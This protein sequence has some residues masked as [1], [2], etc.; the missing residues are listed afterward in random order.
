MKRKRPNRDAARAGKRRKTGDVATDRPSYPLLRKYYPEVV[1]LRQ[2][3]ASRL[4]KKRRRRLQQYGKDGDQTVCQLL[5]KT[6]IGAFQ[7][8][9]VEDSSVVDDDISTFTQQLTNADSSI[10]LTP[11][12][13]KQSEVGAN[14]CLIESV[15]AL[16]DSTDGK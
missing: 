6:V 10:T 7:H 13:F 5:D 3:L 16:E 11:G 1:T 15:D 9:N 14:A 2:Y 12:E 4:P 8:I